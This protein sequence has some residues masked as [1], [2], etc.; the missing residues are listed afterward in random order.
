MKLF[1][2]PLL[3]LFSTL[4]FSTGALSYVPDT[5]MILKKNTR[6]NSGGGFRMIFRTQWGSGPE[7]LLFEEKWTFKHSDMMR[8]QIHGL[9]EANKEFIRDYVYQ[10]G[11]RYRI[12]EKNELVYMPI[13]VDHFERFFHF[14]T[15]N[16]ASEYLKKAQIILPLAEEPIES[17]KEDENA[18]EQTDEQKNNKTAGSKFIHKQDPNLR[19]GRAQGTVAYVFGRPTPAEQKTLLPG[20]WIEQDRFRILKLRLP[21]NLEIVAKDYKTLGKRTFPGVRTVKWQNH[22]ITISTLSIERILVG[23]KTRQFLSPESLKPSKKNSSED[24]ASPTL[25][26]AVMSEFYQRFR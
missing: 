8:V 3:L 21:S 19:L 20:L 23:P 10:D 24:G 17:K 13:E 5:E 2:F 22:Q 4:F 12:N 26:M 15:E 11:R 18:E 7:A 25:G 16:S 6:L 1:L 9:S 14:Q